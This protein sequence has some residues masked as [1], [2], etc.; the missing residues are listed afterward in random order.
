MADFDVTF[1]NSETMYVDLTERG[2]MPCDFGPG[3]PIGDYDG[4]Y[5][6]TPSDQEQTLPTRNKTL[7]GDI[8]IN[9]IPSN[10]GLI[11]WDGSTITVS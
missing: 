9:A 3:V 10:Y 8:T 1:N 7:E 5:E 6:V 11:T 2:M 4:P